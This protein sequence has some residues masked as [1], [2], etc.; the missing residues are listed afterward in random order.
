M[1]VSIPHFQT[2]RELLGPRKGLLLVMTV[3]HGH[4]EEAPGHF[5]DVVGKAALAGGALLGADA[6]VPA[7][8]TGRDFHD[9]LLRR[10]LREG[11]ETPGD[12][13][14]AGVEAAARGE[15]LVAGDARESTVLPL[16]GGYP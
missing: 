14:D 16:V 13:H 8:P 15:A 9:A 5:E 11:V 3:V 6:R 2:S 1:V 10:L 12:P 4:R 7:V